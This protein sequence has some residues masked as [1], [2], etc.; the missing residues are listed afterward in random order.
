MDQDLDHDFI[1]HIIERAGKEKDVRFIERSV[2]K[3]PIG[4]FEVL[5]QEEKD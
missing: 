5:S 2:S 3:I 1:T 4:F